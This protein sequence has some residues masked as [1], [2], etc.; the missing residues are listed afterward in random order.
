MSEFATEASAWTDNELSCRRSDARGTGLWQLTFG[1]GL[2]LVWYV[3]LTGLYG[4]PYF[5]LAFAGIA[6]PVSPWW[7]GLIWVGVQCLLF[8]L[9]RRRAQ[10]GY[11]FVRAEDTGEIIASP[12]PTRLERVEAYGQD[13]DFSFRRG[14]VG[15]YFSAQIAIDEALREFAEIRRT[16][17]FD[18]DGLA[19]L[20][21]L[22]MS[23]HRKLTFPELATLLPGV[24]LLPLLREA[25]MLPGFHIHTQ[26]PQGISLT[27]AGQ[28]AV[29]VSG[30]PET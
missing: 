11:E 18:R 12:P 27:E 23:Q 29:L 26:D 9:V 4:A 5:I 24:D 28:Q 8:P 30:V 7:F 10:A 14:Y 2:M 1:L 21:A 6:F 25:S 15:I 19:R 20:A 22:L 16:R 13:H 3:A 17:R